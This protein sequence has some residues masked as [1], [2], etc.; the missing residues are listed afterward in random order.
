LDK[1]GKKLQLKNF[2]IIVSW[3]PISRKNTVGELL[4][5]ATN[6]LKHVPVTRIAKYYHHEDVTLNDGDSQD[7]IIDDTFVYI[8]KQLQLPLD[9]ISSNNKTTAR[10]NS[11]NENYTSDRSSGR[12]KLS[13]S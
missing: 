8:R 5:R 9:R 10:E 6:A 7:K 2:V 1:N 4:K 13:G 12:S 11:S 3:R